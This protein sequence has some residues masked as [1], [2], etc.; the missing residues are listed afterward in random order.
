MLFDGKKYTAA[1]VEKRGR[2][3]LLLGSFAVYSI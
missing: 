2:G 1:K 3:D